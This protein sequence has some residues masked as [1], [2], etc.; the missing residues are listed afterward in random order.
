MK[1]VI[2]I[3]IAI[4][5]VLSLCACGKRSAD[6]YGIN[7]VTSESTNGGNFVS[8][9]AK[10]AGSPALMSDNYAVQEFTEPAYFETEDCVIEG[11]SGTAGSTA[12]GADSST[13][14]LKADKIIY[15]ANTT[16]ETTDFD[17][18]IEKLN[19]YITEKGG[20]IESSSINDSNYY[21]KSRGYASTRSA[22]YVIRIPSQYFSEAMHTMT[23]FGNV[24]YSYTYTENITA[25]YYDTQSRLDAL[26]VQEAR[27]IELLGTAETVEDIIILEDRISEVRYSIDTLQSR[28]N[29]YDR[30]VAYSTISLSIKEVKEYT[31]ATPVNT[32]FWQELGSSIVY[33]LES[34]LEFI[35]NFMIMLAEN[36]PVLLINIAIIAVVIIV[37]KKLLKKP[38]AKVKNSITEKISN[39][40]KEK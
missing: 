28:M 2:A 39:I 21:N 8:S 19:A 34:A 4:V 15:S 12:N 24:P 9:A 31:P 17:S 27:L 29:N 16:I 33:G 30:M 22:D 40:K 3:I 37:L 38:F 13:E 7:A 20:F 6:R 25:Q 32:S 26:K 23:S 35:Q 36:L 5:L 10:A 11:F 14:L 18:V 1:K